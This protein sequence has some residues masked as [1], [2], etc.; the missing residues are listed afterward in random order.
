KRPGTVS[1]SGHGRAETG[2]LP[3]G[4]EWPAKNKDKGSGLMEPERDGGRE[5]L[6]PGKMKEKTKMDVKEFTEK[7][8]ESLKKAVGNEEKIFAK[9]T[10]GSNGTLVHMVCAGVGGALLNFHMD[11]LYHVH[12]WGMSLE[13]CFRMIK[14]QYDEAVLNAVRS[15]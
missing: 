3:Q 1:D 10:V 4:D 2:N 8:A 13:A 7:M 11:Q 5:G 14:Q 12:Q 9:E 15:E 6:R